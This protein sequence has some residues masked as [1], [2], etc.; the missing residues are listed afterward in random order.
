[1]GTHDWFAVVL[2]ACRTGL[3]KR[4]SGEGLLGMMWGWFV[5]R[6]PSTVT[7]QW[8][9]TGASTATL[10]Q[11]FYAAHQ[12]GES[13]TEA[14]RRAELALFKDRKTRHPFSWAPFVLNGDPW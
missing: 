11:S 12:G 7:S 2:S 9:V 1:M 14:L 5:A 6:V 3:G 13:K 4:E 8:S 10:M